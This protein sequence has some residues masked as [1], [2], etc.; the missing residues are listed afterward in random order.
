MSQLDVDVIN[1]LHE[2]I[3]DGGLCDDRIGRFFAEHGMSM[4]EVAK[5]GGWAPVMCN[6]IPDQYPTVGELIEKLKSV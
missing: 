3:V 6:M 5:Q 2:A 4:E 1:L